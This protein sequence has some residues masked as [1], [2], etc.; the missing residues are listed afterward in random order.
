MRFVCY[1]IVTVLAT[2]LDK[3][4][5]VQSSVTAPASH[6]CSVN[7]TTE[8]DHC[9][10]PNNELGCYVMK[11]VDFAQNTN[12]YLPIWVLTCT[13]IVPKVFFDHQNDFSCSINSTFGLVYC[14][15]LPNAT[16]NAEVGSFHRRCLHGLF[17]LKNLSFPRNFYRNKFYGKN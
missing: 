1:A 2:V 8:S 10:I 3:S 12:G 13:F 15:L 5:Q 4:E 17:L 14:D 9:F 6:N 7:L 11:A 16:T